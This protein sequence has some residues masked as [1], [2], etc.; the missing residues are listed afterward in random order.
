MAG[1]KWRFSSRGERPS[2]ATLTQALEQLEVLVVKKKKQLYI[3]H[4]PIT[5]YLEPSILLIQNQENQPF[6]KNLK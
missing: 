2:N 4:L 6:T 3:I 1:I 5:L